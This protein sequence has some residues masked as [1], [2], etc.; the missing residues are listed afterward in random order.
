MMA[1][2]SAASFFLSLITPYPSL[3]S[4]AGMFTPQSP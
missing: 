4:Q 1:M 2:G 3:E